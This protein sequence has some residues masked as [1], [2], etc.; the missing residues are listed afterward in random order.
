MRL[1]DLL[2]ALD[3]APDALVGKIVAAV[4]GPEAVL[5]AI[6]SSEGGPCL[7][8][9]YTV[10][11]THSGEPRWFRIRAIQDVDDSRTGSILFGSAH[12]LTEAEQI[13]DF[14]RAVADT[15]QTLTCVLDS[16]GRIFYVNPAWDENLRRRNI[17]TAVA[18][19]GAS[20]LEVCAR[21]AAAGDPIAAEVQQGIR[22]VLDGRREKL[23]L[24]YPCDSETESRWFHLLV[25]RTHGYF[26]RAIVR[27]FDITDRK[28]LEMALERQ[29]HQDPLTGLPNAACFRKL[30]PRAMDES[31]A[32]RQGGSVL[33]LGVDDFQTIVHGFGH[34][35]AQ[36][37]ELAVAERLRAVDTPGIVLCAIGR[38]EFL[39]AAPGVTDR[40]VAEQFADQLRR[41]TA[42]PVSA[43]GFDIYLRTSLGVS[44]QETGPLDGAAL[45]THLRGAEIAL[46]R[47]R[48]ETGGS[49]RV[50]DDAMARDHVSAARRQAMARRAL[51]KNE[52]ELHFQP[53]VGGPTRYPAAIETLLRRRRK[54]GSVESMGPTIQHLERSSSIIEIDRWVLDTACRQ[55][56]AWQ[57]QHGVHWPFGTMTVNVSPFHFQQADFVPWLQAVLGETGMPPTRLALEVTERAYIDNE[58]AFSNSIRGAA[59]LGVSS[60]WTISARATRPWTCCAAVGRRW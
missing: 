11:A 31:P 9:V 40:L 59:L 44:I 2:P 35:A 46:L 42:Q 16:D 21:A 14:T 6:D 48:K 38:G 29:A 53:I 1:S 17:R 27:H 60:G 54:D 43:N 55:W 19:V 12:S 36:A 33:H 23:A 49:I 50:F 51:A 45:E 8:E 22:E 7:T 52:L 15:S 32:M 57:S 5:S 34:V 26:G 3:E 47:S 58:E 28:R 13:A 25:C 4:E 30:L 24:D 20:Y 41:V 56:M 39:I 18:G 10:L 37:V